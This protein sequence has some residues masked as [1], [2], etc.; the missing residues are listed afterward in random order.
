MRLSQLGTIESSGSHQGS[1]SKKGISEFPGYFNWPLLQLLSG[2]YPSQC[3]GPRYLPKGQQSR[4]VWAVHQG[5]G[6]PQDAPHRL[7]THRKKRRAGHLQDRPLSRAARGE[8]TGWCG[9][10]APAAPVLTA[11]RR[12]DS[13]LDWRSGPEGVPSLRQKASVRHGQPCSWFWS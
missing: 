9:A 11:H 3:G 10:I 5:M 6:S 7:Q 8:L 12:L 4:R 2:T 1:L 13:P